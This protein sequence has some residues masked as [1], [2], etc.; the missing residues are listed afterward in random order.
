M[1]SVEVREYVVCLFDF[2]GQREGLLRKVRDTEDITSLQGELDK[3][4]NLVQSFNDYMRQAFDVIKNK[5]TDVLRRLGVVEK[6]MPQ[7]IE[8]MNQVHLGIQQYSDT[9]L[10]YVGAEDGEGM[11]FGM[12]IDFC[13]TVAAHF[14][15]TV[16][17][18]MLVRGAITMGKAWEIAPNC[19]YG[20]VMEDVYSME[21]SLANYPR[22]VIS[23]NV[24]GRI[25]KLEK[26]AANANVPIRLLDCLA[27]DFDGMFI[28]DYLSVSTVAWYTV[29]NVNQHALID[30]LVKGLRW[31]RTVLESLQQSASGDVASMRILQKY[32]YLRSYW[33]PRIDVLIEF[34]NKQEQRG[35]TPQSGTDGA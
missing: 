9:T 11:G 18:G 7:F 24:V 1:K 17:E 3:I 6:D 33:N 29:M 32:S 14:L 25:Q 8:K 4:S 2:L 19:L 27:Y 13:L 5:G 20:P 15:H 31:I 30:V 35:K 21:S 34:F 23:P 22:I 28:L 10:I 12:F 16:S 26:E